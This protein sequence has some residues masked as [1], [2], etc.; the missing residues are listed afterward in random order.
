[1]VGDTDI[2]IIGAG[3]YGLSIAAHLCERGAEFRIFG[4]PMGEWRDNMPPGMFLKSEGFA[5]DL[6]DPGRKLTLKK[7]CSQRG[8]AYAHV[9]QPIA[10]EL[11]CDYGLAFQQKFVPS[12]E[13]CR[14]SHVRTAGTSFDIELETGETFRARRVVVAVGISHYA[15]IPPE[16]AGLPADILRH[17]SQQQNLANYEGKTVAVI[18]AGSSAVD[19]AA[20]LHQAGAVTRLLSRR[21]KIWFH[22][23]PET[24]PLSKRLIRKIIKPRSGL[25]LGW[26]SKLA[27]DIP[28][29]FHYM[30]ARFRIRVTRGHLGPS[31]SWM[32]RTLVEG[33]VD[34]RL[35]MKLQGASVRDGRAELE[36][37]NKSGAAEAVLADQVIAGTGYKVNVDRLTFLDDAIRARIIREQATPVLSRHF[38]SS[39]SG[40]YFVGVTAANSFGPLLRFAWGAN[41][42]ARTLTTHL[43]KTTQRPKGATTMQ[44]RRT[45]ASASEMASEVA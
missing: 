35:E 26:R 2:A 27:C 19:M 5:S 1:M 37:V 32:T 16:L 18:G 20:A 34:V 24:L 3:P 4:R 6:F 10:R 33:K 45:R 21:S 43:C 12:L 15:H 11:F 7:Y 42:T 38:E 44:P 40:L 22:Q 9:G 41:F 14:V 8:D 28:L 13:T 23:P 29:F 25:G 30:P 36:F 31:A 17:S 39:F